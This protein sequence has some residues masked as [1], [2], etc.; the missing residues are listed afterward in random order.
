MR[1]SDIFWKLPGKDPQ[2]CKIPQQFGYS[3]LFGKKRMN[4]A[5]VTTC[6]WGPS[7]S[8]LNGRLPGTLH[9]VQMKKSMAA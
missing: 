1:H 8:H 7:T 2:S 3:L 6:M 5:H 9:K 4:F